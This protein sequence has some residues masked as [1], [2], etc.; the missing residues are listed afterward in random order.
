MCTLR[1]EIPNFLVAR[2]RKFLVPEANGLKGLW[3]D[4]A[5]NLV[6]FRPK[7]FTGVRGGGWYGDHDAR[8]LTLANRLRRRT[9]RRPGRQPIVDH[10][11]RAALQIGRRPIAPVQSFTPL[12]LTLF[13]GRRSLDDRAGQVQGAHDVVVEHPDTSRRNGAHRELFV[14]GHAEF[15]NEKDVQ[16]HVKRGRHFEA[17][18]HAASWEREN[19]HVRPPGIMVQPLRQ[20][21]ARVNAISKWPIG[22]Q[23]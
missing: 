17:D 1:E 21:P 16:R 12:E 19:Q 14:A 6:H 22:S 4:G 9:H 8:R 7:L 2:L 5:H 10:D 18:G 3:R 15:P 23:S 11:H 13:D 20:H